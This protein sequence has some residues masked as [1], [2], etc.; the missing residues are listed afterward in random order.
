VALYQGL[1]IF[2]DPERHVGRAAEGIRSNIKAVIEA[3]AHG[4]PYPAD[5][6]DE[7]AWNQMILKAVFVGIPLFPIQDIDRRANL[8]LAR[9]LS[10]F[11]KE[12]W[13]AGR[14]VSPEL[15]RCVGRF[16]EDPEIGKVLKQAIDNGNE[17]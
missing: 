4:N 6:L 13:A 7:P 3:V 9:M 16:A 17:I 8:D 11:A 2:P 10:D 5:H 1:P 15:W 12:R 14:T